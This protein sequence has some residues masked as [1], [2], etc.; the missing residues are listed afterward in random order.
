MTLRRNDG[1]SRVGGV[2][3]GHAGAF[4]FGLAAVTGGVA[5]H[6]PMYLMGKG[7]GY[8]LA[9][10]PMTTAMQIGMVAIIV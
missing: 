1:A 7:S 4:W 8:K 9:G 10:M 2:T 3:F 5:A 6:L